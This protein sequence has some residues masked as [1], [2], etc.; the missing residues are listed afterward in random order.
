MLIWPFS[1]GNRDPW[2][3]QFKLVTGFYLRHSKYYTSN[4]RLYWDLWEVPIKQMTI[5]N[6]PHWTIGPNWCTGLP[7]FVGETL[8]YGTEECVWT[9]R[10]V[11]YTGTRLFLGRFESRSIGSLRS[12]GHGQTCERGWRDKR[13]ILFCFCFC[14]GNV[15]IRDN[16]D[17]SGKF[18]DLNT[19]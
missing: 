1:D 19:L 2:D 8:E 13:I 11:F 3:L 12:E 9:I 18:I 17:L 5:K 14:F 7:V 15:L 16:S 6:G 4:C 10:P